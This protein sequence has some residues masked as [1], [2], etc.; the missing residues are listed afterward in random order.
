MSFKPS[1]RAL[2]V[3]QETTVALMWWSAPAATMVRQLLDGNR[4]EATKISEG[5]EG[6][7][8]AHWPDGS[9]TTTKYKYKI[10]RIIGIPPTMKK[11]VMPKSKAKKKAADAPDEDTLLPGAKKAS[12]KKGALAT[13]AAAEGKDTAISGGKSPRTTL[14]DSNADET[15][16]TKGDELPPTP[17]RLVAGRATDSRSTSPKGVDGEASKSAVVM[18]KPGGAPKPKPA[19]KVEIKIDISKARIGTM[20]YK[21]INGYGVCGWEGSKRQQLMCVATKKLPQEKLAKIAD[22]CVTKISKGEVVEQV[23]D[24]MQKELEKVQAESKPDDK[25]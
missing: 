16:N 15:K 25:S 8:V 5:P 12:P 2:H 6:E 24:W 11:A 7:M 18:K 4:Q 10:G 22:A 1:N 9:Q 19:K 23:K 20:W 14:S 13:A 17:G 3:A 21:N